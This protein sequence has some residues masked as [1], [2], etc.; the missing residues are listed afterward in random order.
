MDELDNDYFSI[1]IENDGQTVSI[2]TVRNDL[3]GDEVNLSDDSWEFPSPLLWVNDPQYVHATSGQRLRSLGQYSRKFAIVW[4]NYGGESIFDL[5][6]LVDHARNNCLGRSFSSQLKC[7]EDTI[8]AYPTPRRQK[9]RC[10]TTATAVTKDI[11]I[12]AMSN[13]KSVSISKFDYKETMEKES[14]LYEAMRDIFEHGAILVQNA[15]DVGEMTNGEGDAEA[16]LQDANSEKLM[17]SIVGDL[18]RRFSGGHLS[19]GSLYGDIF[20]VKSK[21]NAEN[22]AYTNVALPPHQDL[23]YYESKPF[24]QLLHC[25]TATKDNNNCIVGGESVL[26][27]GMAAAEELRRISPDL[28][29]VLLDTEATFIK[30]RYDADMVSPKRHI[31]VDRTCDQVV[32]L[33]WSP[34]FEGP[35]QMH[36]SVAVE[37]YVRAYQALE[38]M[39]DDSW[40][41]MNCNR[42]LLPLTV[43]TL[44]RE[45]AKAYTWERPLKA[46]EILV[47]NNQR[48]LHGRRSFR[49]IGT[50]QRHLIGCYT[51]AIDTTS[52]YRQLLRDKG[53]KCGGGYGRRNPGSGCRWM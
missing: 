18:G 30:E 24:L 52:R 13:P 25:A 12:G 31:V 4:W 16:I 28:F 21:H 38:I 53:W 3:D 42:T 19:H 36:P 15:P 2:S 14:T 46:G 8:G 26:I 39:L 51:D 35:L 10:R 9:E 22:I 7:D 17:E 29:D 1:S 45:Y 11:A 44:L 27:D 20:H 48:M 47:F 37:E 43:E 5:E 40:G 32:E 23:T 34:P 41:D 49:C 50:V 6:W 33:N